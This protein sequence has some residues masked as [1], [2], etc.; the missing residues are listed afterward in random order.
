MSI[1]YKEQFKQEQNWLDKVTERMKS[2]S[3]GDSILWT[4]FHSAKQRDSSEKQLS[5]N[6]ML[7]VI[8]HVVHDAAFQFHSMCIGQDYTAYLNPGQ[9]AVSCG[10]QPLYAL[11]KSL[12]WAHPE[13]F[14]KPY[15]M[16]YVPD[17]FAFFGALHLE[18][19]FLVCTG[20][21]VKGTG[22]EDLL[23]SYGLKTVGLST[24]VCD[25]N[26]IKKSRY[27]GQV[28]ASVLNTLLVDAHKEAMSLGD[29]TEDFEKWKTQQHGDSFEYF[30]GL[31]KH[32][33]NGQ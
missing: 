14:L 12:I 23:S 26:H 22:L 24:A 7:P 25:V 33:L 10:Y 31:L 11:K 2:D 29:S 20:E 16:S 28:L 13:K 6:S 17:V 19:V 27:S 21:V 1:C 9:T 18:Q 5:I 15:P 30:Y 32:L 8:D 4:G 3:D